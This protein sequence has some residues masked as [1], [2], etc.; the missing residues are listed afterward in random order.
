LIVLPDN[1]TPLLGYESVRIGLD[2]RPLGAPVGNSGS[3][4]LSPIA[5]MV[6]S[7]TMSREN[8]STTF[9]VDT[10]T[11]ERALDAR[12]HEEHVQNSGDT[13]KAVSVVLTVGYV[14]VVMHGGTAATNH[15][16]Q[17]TSGIEQHAALANQPSDDEDDEHRAWHND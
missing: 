4:A 2:V 12:T 9:L 7:D 5:W 15:V 13:T 6:H 16:A 8:R 11:H 14:I 1:V 10:K 17:L 3:V